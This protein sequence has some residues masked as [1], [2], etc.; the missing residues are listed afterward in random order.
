[1]HTDYQWQVGV[2]TAKERTDDPVQDTVGFR[3]T[4]GRS[5][6]SYAWSR[7]VTVS[8]FGAIESRRY[9]LVDAVFLTTR[10]DLDHT[11]GLNLD[12]QASKTGAWLLQW[13]RQWNRS[14]IELYRYQR[15]VFSLAWRLDLN[16]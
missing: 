5:Q 10:R 11:L 7:H 6:L 13:G 14:N 12:W 3:S 4:S 1:M 15:N 2:N 9:N 8:G 16:P